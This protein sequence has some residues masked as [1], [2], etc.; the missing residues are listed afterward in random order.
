VKLEGDNKLQE[1]QKLIREAEKTKLE[2]EDQL[3]EIK[4]KGENAKLQIKDAE[5]KSIVLEIEK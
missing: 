5:I 1:A 3:I 4:E 2:F